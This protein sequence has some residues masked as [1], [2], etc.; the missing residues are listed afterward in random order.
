[1][2]LH[3]SAHFIHLIFPLTVGDS[4]AL[5]NVNQY[6]EDF[7][8]SHAV[9]ICISPTFISRTTASCPKRVQERLI[10]SV[11]VFIIPVGP[12]RREVQRVPLA[13]NHEILITTLTSVGL[14]ASS[15]N[16]FF[17]PSIIPNS[18]FEILLLSSNV[19]FHRKSAFD[20]LPASDPN[21]C[22][23]PQGYSVFP[24]LSCNGIWRAQTCH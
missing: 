24:V 16:I 2:H 9:S 20:F 18:T 6:T 21:P 22:L 7:T 8:K 19:V 13:T 3:C 10:E 1:V 4:I 14:G 11:S 23:A 12:Y 17:I 15:R 5:P